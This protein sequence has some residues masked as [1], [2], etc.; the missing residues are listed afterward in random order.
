MRRSPYAVIQL[1]LM[2]LVSRPRLP[3]LSL[4]WESAALARRTPWADGAPKPKVSWARAD[5]K[6]MDPLNDSA[7]LPISEQI[8]GDA[9]RAYI[10]SSP[11][12]I[13]VPAFLSWLGDHEPKVLQIINETT[14]TR[15]GDT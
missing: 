12:L 14:L 11:P 6:A 7:T 9:W 13:L 10:R 15:G 5:I 1:P 3:I 8:V 4:P 2:A